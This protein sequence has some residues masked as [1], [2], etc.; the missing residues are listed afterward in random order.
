MCIG[1]AVCLFE[2]PYYERVKE[3]LRPGGI[4]C[5]QGEAGREGGKERG[6][7]GVKDGMA[8]RGWWASRALVFIVSCKGLV[9]N[10]QF[11]DTIIM[12]YIYLEHIHTRC[13]GAYLSLNHVYHTAHRMEDSLFSPTTIVTTSLSFKNL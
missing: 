10:V 7:E 5:A 3:A 12:K 2:K 4:H 11:C 6:S 13:F 1:P 8:G 9:Y